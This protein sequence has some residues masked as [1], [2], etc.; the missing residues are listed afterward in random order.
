MKIEIENAF[1][2]T[3]INELSP[4][5]LAFVGD[6][7]H[8]MYVRNFVVNNSLLKLNDYNKNC[9]NFCKAKTQ[10]MVLDNLTGE[11]TEKEQEIARRARNTKT[12]NIA[13]NSNLVEYKKAT[14]F[15]AIVGYLYLT[16]NSNR[17]EYILSKSV[18]DI[19]G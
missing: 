14:S 5:V 19:K 9:A 15:E 10:A 12:N 17:L 8:T 6:G 18:E 7:V 1:S 11:L 16:K 3:K 13:K 4:L 2:D